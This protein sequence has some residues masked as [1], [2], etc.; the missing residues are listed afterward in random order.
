MSIIAEALKK[1][2][3]RGRKKVEEPPPFDLKREQPPQAPPKAVP[4]AEIRPP[5]KKAPAPRAKPI[6]RPGTAPRPGPV[7]AAPGAAPAV[8]PGPGPKPGVAKPKRW[9]IRIPVGATVILVF[10]AGIVY[11]VNR[12]YLPGIQS[13]A[14]EI[15]PPGPAPA[16]QTVSESA[17]TELAESPAEETTPAGDRQEEPQAEASSEPERT[18]RE[19]ESPEM[20]EVPAESPVTPAPPLTAAPG[21]EEQPPAELVREEP[22]EESLA[23]ETSFVFSAEETPPGALETPILAQEEGL[24]ELKDGLESPPV[25]V[26]KDRDTKKPLREDIYHFNMAVFFQRQGDIPSALK[27]YDKVLELSPYNAEVYSNMGVLYNQIGEYEKAVAMLQKA[28]LIDPAYSKAHN[29]I[30]LAYYKSGQLDQA[31]EHLNR[32]IQLEPINLE[33]YNNL[34][35]VYKKMDDYQKAEEAFARA[36]S[37][38]P[39]HAPSNYN[40]ALLCEENGQFDRAVEHYR[41]FVRGKGVTAELARKVNQRLARLSRTEPAR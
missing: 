4:G 20:A 29:N 16:A 12:I 26:Q 33:S 25:I 31:L 38:T 1:A 39:D 11:Y 9:S 34:G 10:F 19:R 15:P 27:E 22:V 14:I 7:A 13:T 24:G 36:L 35:L 8:R 37:I 41:A 2:Q 17:E 32:A 23:Q 28:L 3:S 40:M 18:V 6:A 21:P 30:A 5:A